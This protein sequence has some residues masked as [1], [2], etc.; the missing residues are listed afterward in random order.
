[1][2]RSGNVAGG[3]PRIILQHDAKQRLARRV[4]LSEIAMLGFQRSFKTLIVASMLSMPTAAF[5]AVVATPPYVGAL[6]TGL[7]TL[8]TTGSGPINP[9]VIVGFNPQPDPPGDNPFIDFTNAQHPTITQQGT[10]VFTIIF[11][12]TGPSGDPFSYEFGETSPNSDGRFSFLA[13]GDGSVFQVNFGIG[14]L[15][16]AWASFNPQPDPPGI[17]GFG[18]VGDPTLS[19]DIEPGTIDA[20]GAFTPT[21]DALIE[22]SEP[23]TIAVFGIALAGLGAMRRRKTA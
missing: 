22:A 21:G 10:G 3:S 18:F 13:L 4:T 9:G 6:P 14:G 17:V 19:W 20:N 12:L 15:T 16:G 2:A 8:A 1:M 11:G 5:A 23:T 7:H